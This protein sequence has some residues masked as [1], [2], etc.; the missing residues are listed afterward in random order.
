MTGVWGVTF[1]V[2]FVN[3]AARGLGRPAGEGSGADPAARSA[4]LAAI[5]APALIAAPAATGGPGTIAV[6]QVDVR[7][8]AD[9]SP[10]QEDLTVARRNIEEFRTLRGQTPPPD[11][12]VWGEGS[13]DPGALADPAT[14]AEVRPRSER[15]ASRRRSA[16]S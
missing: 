6:V 9:T 10:E 3:A 1:V 4:A 14:V 15:W 7:V 8:P 13:L 16:R 12:A 5:L 11:L 2:V